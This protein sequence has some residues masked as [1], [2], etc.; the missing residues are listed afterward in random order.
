[1]TYSTGISRRVRFQE[2]HY[3]RQPTTTRWNPPDFLCSEP[4]H[5]IALE[6]LTKTFLQYTFQRVVVGCR[7]IEERGKSHVR[8]DESERGRRADRNI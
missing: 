7:E 6:F 2:K 5:Q 4:H 8:T 1:M 3:N